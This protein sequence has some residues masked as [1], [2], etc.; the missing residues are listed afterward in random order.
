M[1]TEEQIERVAEAIYHVSGGM[2]D[3]DYEVA[4]GKPRR[5]WKTDAR[6][7]TRIHDGEGRDRRGHGAGNREEVT[8]A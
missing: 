5:A 3:H 4:M 1:V 8:N 6:L 7:G 2:T